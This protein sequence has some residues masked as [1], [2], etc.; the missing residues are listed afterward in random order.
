VGRV[1]RPLEVRTGFGLRDVSR[2]IVRNVGFAL[3]W[4]GEVECQEGKS[5]HLAGYILGP[6]HI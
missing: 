2:G 5:N 4:A 6:E 3:K 1:V